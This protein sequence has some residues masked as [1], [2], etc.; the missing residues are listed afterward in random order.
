MLTR[1]HLWRV[2]LRVGAELEARLRDALAPDELA[3]AEALAS[4]R[5]RSRF[6]VAR[7][8]LRTLLGSAL[9]ESPQSV[10]IETGASGKPRLAG[11]GRRLGFNVSHSGD[12]ALIC[13][14]DGLKVGVDL[15]AIRP[16]PSAVEIA[17]RRFAPEETRYVEEGASTDVD[18]RFLLCWTRKE[19]LAKAVGTGLNLDLQSFAVPLA[20]PAGIVSL[21]GPS[22]GGE[23]RWL[24]VDVPMGSEYVAAL[25]LPASVMDAAGMAP[26][27]PT[28]T[29]SVQLA[30]CEEIDV[31]PPLAQLEL[32]AILETR[33]RRGSNPRLSPRGSR[34][35]FE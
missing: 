9:G 14:A 5:A 7:G 10:R 22:K 29:A 20:S 25:A 24:L 30:H 31:R 4:A 35:G 21:A 23:Q 26:P 8:T 28:L 2:D 18:R 32:D 6:A 19:A 12:L 11:D 15:E 17:K 27:N 1:L 16:V 13:F 34:S 3:R 33:E